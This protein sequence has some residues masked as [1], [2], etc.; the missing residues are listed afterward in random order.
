MSRARRPP[1]TIGALFRRD[2]LI[3]RYKIRSATSCMCVHAR[4]ATA[5]DRTTGAGRLGERAGRLAAWPGGLRHVD[6]WSARRPRPD[7]EKFIF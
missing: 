5:D 2:P 1:H 3:T 7:V 6:V 4:R